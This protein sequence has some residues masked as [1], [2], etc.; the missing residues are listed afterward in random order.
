MA[1]KGAKGARMAARIIRALMERERTL[2]ELG[3]I[4][5]AGERPAVAP[6]HYTGLRRFL[7]GLQ[8][9][10]LPLTFTR[11]RITTVSLD[12]GALP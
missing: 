4:A 2:E 10:G 3:T 11:G 6:P 5:V 12:V 9:G 1:H 7:N 8:E